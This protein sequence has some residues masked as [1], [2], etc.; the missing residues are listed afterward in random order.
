MTQCHQNYYEEMDHIYNKINEVLN[1]LYKNDSYLL[2]IDAHEVTIS[3]KL[4]CYLQAIFKEFDVD[5]EFNKNLKDSK[6]VDN[7]IRRPDIIV[8]KRGTNDSNFIAIEIKKCSNANKNFDIEKIGSIMNE[9]NYEYGFYIEF[10]VG[11]D[12]TEKN[13]IKTMECFENRK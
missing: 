1:I 12:I 6:R 13:F 10:N 8:H 11:E 3:H 2:E 7:E 4:A 9:L 5:I